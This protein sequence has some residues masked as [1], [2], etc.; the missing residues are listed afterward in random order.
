MRVWKVETV[1]DA[2]EVYT[3]EADTEQEARAAFDNGTIGPA[4]MTDVTS[5]EIVKIE[6]EE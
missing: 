2:R 6:E 5:A 1:G 3:V 4:D